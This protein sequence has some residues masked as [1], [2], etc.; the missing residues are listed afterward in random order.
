MSAPAPSQ[1]RL[2]RLRAALGRRGPT[3]MLVTHL[4]NVRWLCGFS[5]S[6]GS[7]L[8]GPREALF[9]TDFRYRIQAARE[10]RGARRIE[11]VGGSTAAIAHAVRK[12]R[13]RR[14]GFEAERMSVA[15][16][17]D[18]R[19]A[20]P[21]VEFVPLRGTVEALRTVKDAGEIAAIRNA[22]AVSR[23]VL[24]AVTHRLRGRTELELAERLRAAIVREGG[25]QESFPTIV[26][27]GGHAAQ[28]HAVPTVKR[29][30]GKELVIVDYGVRLS[31]YCSDL[32]RTFSPGGWDKTAREIYR[33]VLAAQQAAI[34][35]IRPGV[36]ASRVDEAARGVIER[37]GYGDHFGHGTG[38]G[39]GLEV[40]EGPTLSPKSGDVLRPGMVV[41]VEPGIY[42]QDYGGVRIE[43]MVLV[44]PTGREVLSRRVP[45]L[46]DP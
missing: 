26:A 22:L 9:F 15:A 46:L 41:T 31:G 16:H 5:G 4:P 13:I 14:L 29:I 43:D 30:G 1:G 40:H 12:A 19:A 37:S 45:K 7:L 8:I 6:A 11:H 39:V 33:V 2:P 23:R 34:S 3:G 20:L 36:K 18:L 35:S 27:S 38:H 17:A 44:T 21:G 42:L 10:V 25:E 28:P 24:P 32:T